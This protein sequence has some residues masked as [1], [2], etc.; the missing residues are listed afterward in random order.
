MEKSENMETTNQL[1]AELLSKTYLT[2][3]EQ[4]LIYDI[5]TAEENRHKVIDVI[6]NKNSKS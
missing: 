6:D 5:K 1:L 2:E 4:K 3:Y